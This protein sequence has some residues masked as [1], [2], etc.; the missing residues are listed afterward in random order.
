MEGTSSD[1]L[2]NALPDILYEMR[3][4]NK[5]GEDVYRRLLPCP[6]DEIELQP[7]TRSPVM[8]VVETRQT[9]LRAGA[10]ELVVEQPKE[11]KDIQS[12]SQVSD[13]LGPKS[14][15]VAGEDPRKTV[16]ETRVEKVKEVI[17]LPPFDHLNDPYIEIYSPA[18]REALRSVCDYSP[19]L[20]FD[21]RSLKLYWPYPTLVYYDSALEEYAHKFGNPKCNKADCS[22]LYAQRH[23][24]VVRSFIQR[25]MGKALE[26]ERKRH[27]RG[28]ATFDMLWLL[29][30][31]GEDV[32][33]DE[34]EMDEYEP[35]V[36]REVQW[37]VV[38]GGIRSYLVTCFHL[39]ANTV[40]IGPSTST[41]TIQP[42][43][44]ERKITSLRAFPFKCL[45]KGKDGKTPEEV[46][47]AL[48]ERGK[49]FF[50]LRKKGVWDFRGQSLTFPRRTVCRP[51]LDQPSR[52]RNLH[53][54][55]V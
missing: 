33:Y 47:A 31:L 17:K 32:M 23:I 53:A 35:W 49:K 50:Q 41:H 22:G 37:Q 48:I 43:S 20:N 25:T 13:S 12:N 26:E 19:H 14:V 24:G 36:I 51:S 1:D 10:P 38:D 15:V 7:E 52:P 55:V 42:F 40:E 3:Y 2:E 18:V 8:K 30:K 11:Q 54:D 4:V 46:K 16:D 27:E 29:Y 45:E 21:M 34:L 5:N 44:G 9:W 28:Y 39:A 6:A